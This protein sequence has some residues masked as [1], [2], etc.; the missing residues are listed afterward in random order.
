MVIL[1]ID[2]G[3]D[4]CGIA[5]LKTDKEILFHQVIYTKDLLFSLK[6]INEEFH[7]Q[8]IVGIVMGNGTGGNQ[9]IKIIQ[10][11]F[12]NLPIHIVD[13]YMSTLKART[14]Y[15]KLFPPKGIWMF[16]PRSLL[17]PPKPYDDIAAI[18][19]VEKYLA[20]SDKND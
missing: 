12:P 4:K 7:F 6:K 1:G 16:I 20:G 19:L 15:W 2:P 13:E 8:E 3:R 14:R 17:V 5:L 10:D 9:I 18:I 11:T